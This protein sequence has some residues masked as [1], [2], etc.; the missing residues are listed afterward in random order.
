MAMCLTEQI[1]RVDGLSKN[2]ELVVAEVQGQVCGVQ[3]LLCVFDMFYN[4]KQGFFQ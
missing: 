3:P 1:L 2:H 4:K